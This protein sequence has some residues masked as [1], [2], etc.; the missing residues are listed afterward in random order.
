MT[1]TRRLKTTHAQIIEIWRLIAETDLTSQEIADRVGVGVRSV[2][3]LVRLDRMPDPPRSRSNTGYWGV[4]SNGARNRFDVT[5][6]HD[7]KHYRLGVYR[8]MDDA[9]RAYDAK[10]RELGFPPERLNF[11]D[12]S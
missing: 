6:Y 5:L 7:G 11:P 9:A 12:H 3:R 1:V 2:N 4:S 10:G 8:D